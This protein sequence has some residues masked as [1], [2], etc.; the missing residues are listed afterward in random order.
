MTSLEERK[1]QPPCITVLYS[2]GPYGEALWS[3]TVTGD[4]A[5]H[6]PV[7]GA[8]CGVPCMD[9]RQGRS[10]PCSRV[11]RRRRR[12]RLRG[13]TSRRLY[14]MDQAAGLLWSSGGSCLRPDPQ[15]A[16]PRCSTCV[17]QGSARC[18]GALVCPVPAQ[19]L[20]ASPLNAGLQDLCWERLL[21]GPP[22]TGRSPGES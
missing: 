10:R 12:R 22:G 3:C 9:S 6:T 18:P 21:A 14:T 7:W 16:T 19:V 4:P 15:E 5:D 17:V 13:C 1:G 8:G 20:T 11:W 2:E